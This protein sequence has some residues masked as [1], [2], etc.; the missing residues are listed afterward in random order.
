MQR[1]PVGFVMSEPR[2]D[3]SFVLRDVG[4][5]RLAAEQCFADAD[6]GAGEGR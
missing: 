6:K 1:A 5:Q 3:G 4:A 2:P